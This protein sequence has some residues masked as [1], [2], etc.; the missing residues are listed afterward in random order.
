MKRK[1]PEKNGLPQIMRMTEC[2]GNECL[3][4]KMF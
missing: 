1:T 2:I 3:T 4:K